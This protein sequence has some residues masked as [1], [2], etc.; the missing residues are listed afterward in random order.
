MAEENIRQKFRLKIIEK[1]TNYFINEI[2]QN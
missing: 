1:I 2:K